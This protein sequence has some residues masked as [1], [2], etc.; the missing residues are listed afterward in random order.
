LA[1]MGPKKK[2]GGGGGDKKQQL[3][4]AIKY[5]KLP[6]LRYGLANAGIIPASRNG[7]GLTTFLL[8]S[9]FGLDK[10][11]AEMVRWYERR[12]RE[13]RECIVLC[14]EDSER[15]CLHLACIGGHS[16]CVQI[17]LDACSFLDR[18][19]NTFAKSQ[20]SLQ[21]AN[22]CTPRELAVQMNKTGCVEVIDEFLREPSEEEDEE[23]DTEEMTSTQLNK[24]KKLA[25]KEKETAAQYIGGGSGSSDGSSTKEAKPERGV[26]PMEMPSPIWPEVEAWANSVKLLRPLC[27]LNIDHSGGRVAPPLPPNDKAAEEPK[28]EANE[29]PAVQKVVTSPDGVDPA[30]WYCESLNRLQLRLTSGTLT[31]LRE[32]GLSKLIHLTTLIV[33]GNS[34]ES[35]PECIGDLPLKNIDCSRNM[36]TTLP[37]NM[38][39]KTLEMCDMSGNSID[40]LGSLAG[41]VELVT[42][43]VDDNNLENLDELNY[44]K[45][46]RIVKLSACNNKIGTLHQGIGLLSK[47]ESL[48]LNNNPLS[49]I[50]ADLGHC[51]K[52]KDLKLDDCPLKDNKIRKYLTQGEMKQLFKYLEKNSG[53]GGGKKGKKK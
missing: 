36:I 47:L 3:W 13:L 30:L 17:L 26:L 34:L 14:D 4:D 49:E 5:Q 20:L 19:K 50:P 12:D 48:I 41:C 9:T 28:E 35:L 40:S 21:D 24:L 29:I 2:S 45:L 18:Q 31:L 51:K 7:D 43:A 27:E 32:D 33:S 38:P 42:L 25:L 15:S 6:G 53:G 37:F 52:L 23:E 16:E 1:T 8:A 44:A 22:G 11:L 39:S 46:G 10:S